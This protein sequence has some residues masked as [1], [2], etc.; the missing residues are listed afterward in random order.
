MLWI[1]IRVGPKSVIWPR[2][3]C[4]PQRL[5]DSFL[6]LG[7]LLLCFS[8]TFFHNK[9]NSSSQ[10]SK[11]KLLKEFWAR[12]WCCA[13]VDLIIV[14]PSTFPERLAS[15]CLG[16]LFFR[17]SFTFFGGVC[18]VHNCRV[19]TP[20]LEDNKSET[21]ASSSCTQAPSLSIFLELSLLKFSLI[22]VSLIFHFSPTIFF[23]FW[24]GFHFIHT[25]PV[26][27]HLHICCPMNDPT[28]FFLELCRLL[29]A[30]KKVVKIANAFT[31]FFSASPS[32][33][34]YLFAD[35]SH[36]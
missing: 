20:L 12:R 27:G 29:T 3:M 9:Q 8:L 5:R 22:N 19:C 32:S 16:C 25:P 33:Y 6:F 30:E 14:L 2:E 17:V 1:I 13:S 26:V 31:F 4:R 36:G 35:D 18:F 23:F 24:G 7:L 15:R 28:I 10:D 21:D 34:M 11:R